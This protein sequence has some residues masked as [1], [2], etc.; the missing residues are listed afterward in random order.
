MYIEY[1]ILKDIKREEKKNL[2]AKSVLPT[3]QS[4]AHIQIERKERDS[5]HR[6]RI[7]N[8]VIALISSI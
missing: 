8:N 6:K 2:L 4:S 3:E 7:K 5:T 1:E